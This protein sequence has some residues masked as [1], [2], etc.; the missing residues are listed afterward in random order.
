MDT[1]EVTV[2][3]SAQSVK[4]TGVTLDHTSG[5]IN[6]GQQVELFATI[7][8]ANVT[9]DSLTWTSS[10]DTVATIEYKGKVTE[11]G[12]TKYLAYVKGL[13]KGITSIRVVTAAGNSAKA[14][15]TVQEDGSA[16]WEAASL[17]IT[18]T[19]NAT[20]YM[21]KGL[22]HAVAYNVTPT[23]ATVNWSTSDTSIATVDSRGNVTFNKAGSVRVTATALIGTT[24]L[25]DSITLTIV[26]DRQG[27]TP[28]STDALYLTL[29][30]V[31]KKDVIKLP[32][33]NLEITIIPFLQGELAGYDPSNIVWD[34]SSR[35]TTMTPNGKLIY[36]WQATV[37]GTSY[38]QTTVTAVAKKDGKEYK[39]T[40]TVYFY[41]NLSWEESD[42]GSKTQDSL[43]ITLDGKNEIN[44]IKAKWK[45]TLKDKKTLLIP[46]FAANKYTSRDVEWST[47]S[48]IASI[49]S[50]G[51]LTIDVPES[52]LA[53][54]GTTRFTVT[55]KTTDGKLIDTADVVVDKNIADS[56]A[57]I[58]PADAGT[59]EGDPFTLEFDGKSVPDGSTKDLGAVAVIDPDHIV[60]PIM[61][62]N[63]LNPF[64]ASD[65]IWSTS[66]KN[67]ADV[68][69]KGNV[70]VKPV[71]TP[72]EATITGTITDGT[73]TYSHSFK[74]K[75]SPVDNTPTGA[76][77]ALQ[78]FPTE[79]TFSSPTDSPV[80]IQADTSS[81]P[82][83]WQSEN[84]KIATVTPKETK[85]GEKPTITPVAAG[86][87][88]IIGTD[89][90]GNKVTIHVVVKAGDTSPYTGMTP[91]EIEKLIADRVA[92]QL[93]NASTGGSTTGKTTTGNP[94]TGVALAVVPA[95]VAGAGAFLFRKKRK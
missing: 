39:A 91:E 62:T 65:V 13:K 5:T 77:R 59:Y 16:T 23:T 29:D 34:S 42:A 9:D 32:N 26:D 40:A 44:T 48:N 72:S 22:S 79:V 37:A 31:T 71:T 12:K 38:N 28:T 43:K 51:Y 33:Q 67:V 75:V 76:D 66:D 86:E 8:P 52:G 61:D 74:V 63:T 93:K 73:K 46:L 81:Y 57:N 27:T 24:Q 56:D 80:A 20:Y 58:I 50:N 89:N 4:D 78:T 84:V 54:D 18:D 70:T 49:D 47:S 11:G 14:E 85:E 95:A 68:D 92:E 94:K 21:S 87:T 1:M 83:K 6:V 15:I 45:P 64:K 69:S 10:D 36:N 55:A 19:N 35:L 82:I 25:S 88:N 41:D 90:K 7:T 60:K 2:A 3:D 53:S 17:K 30:G